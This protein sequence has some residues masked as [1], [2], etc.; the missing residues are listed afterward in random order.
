MA[1]LKPSQIATRRFS[2]ARAGNGSRSQTSAVLRSV[3]PR[4]CGEWGS[5]ADGSKEG[6]GSAPR[7]RGMVVSFPIAIDFIRFS[8]ARAGNGSPWRWAFPVWSVQPR[9]CGEWDNIIEQGRRLRGSAPRVRGMGL[10]IVGLDI[11]GRFSPARAGNGANPRSPPS[12]PPV[13]PRACGEWS[14]YFFTTG[15]EYGSA[16]RVRG[17]GQMPEQI[18]ASGR[19][20]PAR[21]GNGVPKRRLGTT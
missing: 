4:A 3:Q 17:M 16:P 1:K 11:Q 12:A 14:G 20:S 18:P 6:D 21:A 13:Q 15:P 2:P 19:F 7:V 9:A 5:G 10:Q 8:P